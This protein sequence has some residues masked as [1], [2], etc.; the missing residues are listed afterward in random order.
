M[1]EVAAIKD[2]VSAFEITVPPLS[3]TVIVNAVILRP[4]NTLLLED[5]L[6]TAQNVIDQI[7]A[8]NTA[9]A[10][11]IAIPG[12]IPSGVDSPIPFNTSSA[13]PSRLLPMISGTRPVRSRRMLSPQRT[14]PP[15]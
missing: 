6:P 14:R 7:A 10:N 8:M 4:S 5:P 12:S 2:E 3:I 13:A 1:I 11:N 15:R 9:S